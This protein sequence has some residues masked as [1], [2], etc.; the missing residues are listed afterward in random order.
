MPE[1]EKY[2]KSEKSEK[3]REKKR[4]IRC[5]IC[6]KRAVERLKPYRLSLCESCFIRFYE[7]QV[8]RALKKYRVIKSGEKVLACVSGGKDSSAMLAVLKKLSE[9]FNF[10][11]E[12]LHIDLGIEKGEYSKK[13]YRV[14]ER[15]CSSLDVELHV[16]R[17]EDYGIKLENFGRKKCSA[18]GTVKRYIMNRF[19]RENGFDCIAT[20]HNADDIVVFFFRNWL[21]GNFSWSTKFLPR[22][23]GFDRVVTKIR[24]L[25]FMSERENALYCICSKLPF[26]TESCPYAPEDDWKEII[27]EIE[28]RKPGFKR[29]FVTN[30]IKY[31]KMD[32]EVDRGFEHC[33]FCGEVTTSDV[34]AF[35]RLRMR[36]EKMRK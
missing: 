19:A 33:K 27:Y 31:L 8:E 16:T 34:C 25:Y 5:K 36:S 7:R 29:Q 10:T 24:P 12:A 4:R 21:S 22:T 26:L 6:G 35:C 15:L 17:V 32:K 1:S 11:V 30:L 14:S 23:E 18:C 20:G 9:V 3:L 2:G 13:S 28:R